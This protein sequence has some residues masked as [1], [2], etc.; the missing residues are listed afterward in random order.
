[1]I[2]RLSMAATTEALRR[3]VQRLV[4]R[5]GKWSGIVL[6]CRTTSPL[7]ALSALQSLSMPGIIVSQFPQL[8]RQNYAVRQLSLLTS[9]AVTPSGISSLSDA[10][11]PSA[12]I[13]RACGRSRRG[14]D[15][16]GRPT[17]SGMI[18]GQ[19]GLRGRKGAL[20]TTVHVTDSEGLAAELRRELAEMQRRLDEAL[21]ERDEGEAQRAAMPEILQ[22]INSSP[23][24]P[25]AGVRCDPG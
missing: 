5:G 7:D 16:V 25:R 17:I 14:R 11:S 8:F 18:D 1:M 6:I 10:N 21:A 22:V 19:H 12:S 9:R 15:P 23:G 20:H 2:L 13:S 4:S 24:D 3:A